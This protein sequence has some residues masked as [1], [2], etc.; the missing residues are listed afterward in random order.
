MKRKKSIASPI[1]TRMGAGPAVG[2]SQVP[3]PYVVAAFYPGEQRPSFRRTLDAHSREEAAGL[4]AT[5]LTG[6]G[7][8]A[9]GVEVIACGAG[10]VFSTVPVLAPS[11][12]PGASR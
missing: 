4:M 10:E 3:L 2:A 12:R 5:W 6:E 9:K 8:H 11:P 1:P 7:L